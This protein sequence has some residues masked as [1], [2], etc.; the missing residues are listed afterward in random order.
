MEVI[1]NVEDDDQKMLCLFKEYS[2][3]VMR[4]MGSAGMKKWVE[5]IGKGD[6]HTLQVFHCKNDLHFVL[7]LNMFGEVFH[8]TPV[9]AIKYV[10][11]N[12]H[13][14]SGGVSLFERT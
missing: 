6:Q 14:L 8:N 2:M 11:Q 7:I 13:G 10:H 12:L 5:N 4:S 3:L 1:K 9:F